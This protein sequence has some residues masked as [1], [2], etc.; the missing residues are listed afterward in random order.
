MNTLT[1]LRAIRTTAMSA[2]PRT[3]APSHTAGALI[4]GRP[5]REVG[6]RQIDATHHDHQRH[7]DADVIE[8]PDCCLPLQALALRGSEPAAHDPAEPPYAPGE[9][10][11]ERHKAQ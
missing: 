11:R 4:V 8:K 1:K 7:D 9:E 5:E 10:Q 3:M 2:S 6:E